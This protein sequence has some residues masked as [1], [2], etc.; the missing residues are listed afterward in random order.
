MVDLIDANALKEW[1]E[2]RRAKLV[3]MDLQ[4]ANDMIV[5]VDTITIQLERTER[6][7]CANC[8]KREPCTLD[9]RGKWLCGYDGFPV[10]HTYG[11]VRWEP[12]DE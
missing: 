2:N 12:C 6:P 8:A 9:I 4:S 1:L 7:R 10:E 5:M 11:C 3:L